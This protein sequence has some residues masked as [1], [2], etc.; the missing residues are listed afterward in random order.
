MR[1][2]QA[3]DFKVKTTITADPSN[4]VF[5]KCEQD[6]LTAKLLV[7]SNSNPAG[8][9]CGVTILDDKGLEIP[10]QRTVRSTILQATAQVMYSPFSIHRESSSGKPEALLQSPAQ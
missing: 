3:L 6:I 1:R 5:L 10:I 2:G 7:L 4:M 9:P 8:L